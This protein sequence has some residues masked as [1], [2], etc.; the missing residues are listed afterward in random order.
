MGTIPLQSTAA[1][2]AS[3]PPPPPQTIILPNGSVKWI[4]LENGTYIRTTDP[5]STTD[6]PLPSTITTPLPQTT[7]THSTTTTT[8]TI[9]TTTSTPTT[10][11]ATTTKSTT[12]PI[13]ITVTSTAAVTTSIEPTD[14]EIKVVE[15][16]ALDVVTTAQTESAGP[17]VSEA[18]TDD[19]VIFATPHPRSSADNAEWSWLNDTTGN[20]LTEDQL[21]DLIKL[22]PDLVLQESKRE[23]VSSDP[24]DETSTTSPAPP[25]TTTEE[26]EGVDPLLLARLC[27]FQKLCSEQEVKKV[28]ERRQ[29]SATTST[30]AT[31]ITTTTAT[32]KAQQDSPTESPRRVDGVITAQIRRCIQSPQ[33]CSTD[34]ALQASQGGRLSPQNV[35]TTTEVVV[36][37]TTEDPVVETA[38]RCVLVGDCPEQ[39]TRE[40]R[41]DEENPSVLSPTAQEDVAARVRLCLFAKVC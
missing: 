7:I 37:T 1:T 26:E 35:P 25:T 32:V 2:T 38:K 41:D 18:T 11:T 16:T 13:Q 24:T 9:T 19:P 29:Q 8:T 17:L 21:K 12:T 28:M 39:S 10:T 23:E 5:V 14:K 27:L 22:N 4:Q 34:L 33:H 36:T 3:P 6:Q 15:P 20:Q 40:P 30:E 31:V